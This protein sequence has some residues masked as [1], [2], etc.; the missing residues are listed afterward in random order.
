MYE[1]FQSRSTNALEA[2][3]V[4]LTHTYELSSAGG[5]SV[6]CMREQVADAISEVYVIGGE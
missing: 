5:R 1:S 3:G 4:A 2:F 6:P